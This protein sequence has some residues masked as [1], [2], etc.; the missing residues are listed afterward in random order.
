[1]EQKS[2]EQ[3]KK[4]FI[5]SLSDADKKAILADMAKVAKEHKDWLFIL[6]NTKRDDDLFHTIE[7]KVVGTATTLNE[8]EHVLN[9]YILLEEATESVIEKALKLATDEELPGLEELCRKKLLTHLYTAEKLA[10]AEMRLTEN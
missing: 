3:L 2:F 9:N 7:S 8:L 5:N 6:G 4:E 10:R 1:M